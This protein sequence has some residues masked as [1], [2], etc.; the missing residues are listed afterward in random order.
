MPQEK[1]IIKFEPD[2]H[3]D[4]IKALNNLAKAQREVQNAVASAGKVVKGTTVTTQKFSTTAAGLTT[5]LKA[6]GMSWKKLGVEANLVKRAY[7]G[8]KLAIEK[9]RVAMKQGH[10][11]SRLL[12]NSFAT[13]R[14]QLLLFQFAMAMGIRQLIKFADQ[15]A[16]IESMSRAFNTLA[17]GGENATIA[18]DKL[19]EAT[20]NTMSEFDLFQQANNAM[21]L[22]VTKNSDEM[23]EMFD[24]AQRLGRAL[25]VDTKLSVESLIVGIGRQSRMMLDN[26]GIVTRVDEANQDYASELKKTVEQLT[27]AEKKQAFLN[28][29]MVAARE[30]LATMPAEIKTTQDAYDELGAA[31][32]DAAVALGK[33]FAEVFK[34]PEISEQSADSLRFFSENIDLISFSARAALTLFLG[35][36]KEFHKTAKDIG[37]IGETFEKVPDLG[38]S[39]DEFRMPDGVFDDLDKYISKKKETVQIDVDHRSVLNK[40]HGA[41]LQNQK[42]INMSIQSYSDATS[43]YSDNVNTRMQMD[44]DELKNR[45]SYQK[46]DAEGRKRME[47]TVTKKYAKDR[48]AIAIF[49]KAQG[50]ASATI[51]S[52]QGV[53]TALEDANIPLAVLIGA[54]GAIQVGLIATTP[55]PKFQRGGMIGGRRHSQGGTM[56]EAEQGEFI[57]NRNA[58]ESIGLENMNRMNRGGGGGA[59]TVNVSGNVLT[60][61]FVTGELAEAIRES[62][63]R[64]TDFG[65]S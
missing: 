19:R 20:N 49:D 64:G 3:K 28:A 13:L 18:M 57:M 48:T 54:L 41:F 22:G 4:L 52:A 21:I 37:E 43:A 10:N 11:G 61:D 59:I 51:S 31:A 16:K 5:K 9:L 17:G 15:A 35:L 32:S 2:G 1:I 46:A 14:S 30:K 45:T 8:N 38:I 26:I 40:V 33:V 44:M 34:L 47:E 6:Q 29:T 50:I 24:I 53:A 36:P 63:R 23:A 39:S 7:K 55:L 12:H 56:I 65:I 25:G 42:A 62:A 58:V 60:E 27:D